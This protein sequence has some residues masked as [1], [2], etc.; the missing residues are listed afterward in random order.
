MCLKNVHS[1]CLLLI[2]SNKYLG[3]FLMQELIPYEAFS[4]LFVKKYFSYISIN[5]S[6]GT[7][8]RV[9]LEF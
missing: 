7:M 5:T 9:W 3:M 2:S 4:K 6:I 1:F 8:L